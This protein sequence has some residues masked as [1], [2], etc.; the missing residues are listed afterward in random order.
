MPRP[1]C[2]AT[3]FAA[4]PCWSSRLHL[5]VRLDG[6]DPIPIPPRAFTAPESV[7]L[8]AP[9]CPPG[10]PRSRRRRQVRLRG[11]RPQETR[12]VADTVYIFRH[13]GHQSMFVA[14]PYGAIATDPTGL[15]TATICLRKVRKIT[16]APVGYVVYTHHHFDLI[17]GGA[18]FRQGRRG[19]SSSRTGWPRSASSASRIPTCWCRT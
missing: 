10:P 13:L 5:S 19:P 1:E 18:P 2:G 9:A 3:P 8:S 11:R 16:S 17:A 6:S 12:K 14:T 7:L 15:P 4:R